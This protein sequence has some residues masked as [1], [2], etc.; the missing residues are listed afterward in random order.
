MHFSD[1]FTKFYAGHYS[2]EKT[3]DIYIFCAF[4]DGR[5]H[6]KAIAYKTA[7]GEIS[8]AEGFLRALQNNKF[9]YINDMIANNKAKPEDALKSILNYKDL[10]EVNIG[11]IIRKAE[12]HLIS[13][14]E[15]KMQ[16]SA[17]KAVDRQTLISRF[18]KSGK[19]VPEAVRVCYIYINSYMYHLK[20]LIS[21]LRE[22]ISN[23]SNDSLGKLNLRANIVG[24]VQSLVTHGEKVYAP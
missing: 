6:R 16:L 10:G 14:G 12:K 1:I 2:P 5:G 20:N 3:A 24:G 18:G 13:L 22:F 21:S 8:D 17:L 15:F 4:H 23:P 11:E 7:G 19:E 9:T